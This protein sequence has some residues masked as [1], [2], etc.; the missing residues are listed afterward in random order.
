M[1]GIKSLLKREG[2]PPPMRQSPRQ[3]WW[4]GLF[5]S[6]LIAMGSTFE[7][8]RMQRYFSPPNSTQ[9]WA[10]GSITTVFLLAFLSL[11]L[12]MTPSMAHRVTGT[13][14]ELALIII[15]AAFT[16]AAV[17]T[18]TNPATGMAINASGGISFGNLYYSTWA[19]FGCGIALLLSFLRTE[20][21]MDVTN[22]LKSRGRRFRLWVILVIT[23]LIVMGSSASSYDVFCH[24]EVIPKKYCR[25]SA[26]GVS[27]GCIGCV[28]SLVVV[29]IRLSCTKR[30]NG[31]D[32][33]NKFIFAAECITSL[34]L[35][36]FYCF[37]VAYLTSEK[38]PGAPLGNL[39]YST[40]ISFILIFLVATS[41]FEEYQAAKV[42]YSLRNQTGSDQSVGGTSSSNTTNQR[43]T[44]LPE[45][46]NIMPIE[47]INQDEVGFR[48]APG[49]GRS[50]SV[51]EVLI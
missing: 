7:A 6:S 51:G 11:A 39:F 33:P 36:C 9:R 16:C 12:Q 3:L 40:W 13:K 34:V 5:L 38:G 1:K 30:E 41:C 25:R 26:F 28:F 17:G 27:A 31:E 22:E 35:L 20:R 32:G 43:L 10:V 48:P 2:T 29:A 14:V 44:D 46:E 42:V 37:A 18:A 24:A 15:A 4:G 49:G 8:V 21:G 23:S 47:P 19:S 50:G 45:N